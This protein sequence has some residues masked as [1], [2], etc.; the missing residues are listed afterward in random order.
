MNGITTITTKGQV[1]IPLSIRQALKAKIGDK[2][3]FTYFSLSNRQLLIKIIPAEVV[4]DLFGS[5]SSKVKEI[6]FKKARRE[7]GE[8]L[9]KKYQLR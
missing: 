7:A 8:L 6:D 2:V 5:L 4:G 1:T 9:V 3:D